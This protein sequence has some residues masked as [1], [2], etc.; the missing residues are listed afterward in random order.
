MK[1]QSH[2]RITKIKRDKIEEL[3]KQAELISV[4]DGTVVQP[5]G[6]DLIPYPDMD[7]LRL[8]TNHYLL[9]GVNKIYPTRIDNQGTMY[10]TAIVDGLPLHT[11][12]T[13]TIEG[14]STET[15][16]TGKQLNSNVLTTIGSPTFNETTGVVSGFSAS[17]Y[18]QIKPE[19]IVPGT[20]F[21]LCVIVGD[22]SISTLQRIDYSYSMMQLNQKGSYIASW[23]D[24]SPSGE[25][26]VVSNL[27]TGQEIYIKTQYTDST[28]VTIRYS[29]DG[30]EYTTV[31]DNVED[32][33]YWNST[34]A[35][36]G[37]LYYIGTNPAYPATSAQYFHGS[38]DFSKSYVRLSSGLPEYLATD[39]TEPI[40]LTS[41]TSKPG[42]W[43]S[44][45]I[46]PVY[47]DGNGSYLEH[48][49]VHSNEGS[50][51][52]FNSDII[53]NYSYSFIQRGKF[54]KH[55]EGNWDDGCFESVW[56]SGANSYNILYSPNIHS[57]TAYP[58]LWAFQTKFD[59]SYTTYQSIV[60]PSD[61]DMQKYQEADSKCVSFNNRRYSNTEEVTLYSS[62][63]VGKDWKYEL[64]FY[65]NGNGSGNDYGNGGN[66]DNDN[67]FNGGC[68]AGTITYQDSIN[69]TTCTQEI[70][71]CFQT[72]QSYFNPDVPDID[73][74]SEPKPLGSTKL[75]YALHKQYYG[76]GIFATAANVYQNDFNSSN[77][78][79]TGITG[80]IS[81]SMAGTRSCLNNSVDFTVNYFDGA[82]DNISTGHNF[83]KGPY[84]GYTE[85]GGNCGWTL[86]SIG[87]GYPNIAEGGCGYCSCY[88][89]C[90][91]G[92]YKIKFIEGSPEAQNNVNIYMNIYDLKAEA[93]AEGLPW[94]GGCGE[95][96]FTVEFSTSKCDKP[97][98]TSRVIAS[99]VDINSLGDI[100]RLNN[101]TITG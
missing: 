63:L 48:N 92:Q 36:N 89:G 46:Y 1:R 29:F 76:G 41:E 30:S 39:T 83:V 26:V 98:C 22:T 45:F 58:A 15:I 79:P 47:G 49:K 35:T 66:P 88:L 27:T 57:C 99:N 61:P 64:R 19:Y 84:R 13:K 96:R 91:A 7:R 12:M 3:L 87:T 93:E 71:S 10:L 34:D 28:H 43:L 80:T 38:I 23:K 25:K 37:T 2:Q 94:T 52:K 33:R 100:S 82:N 24:T 56:N 53:G 72:V 60:V 54:A 65:G 55:T 101:I 8:W 9:P 31:Y 20:E 69:G 75:Y 32:A 18:Y 44:N 67:G 86:G 74:W 97:G 81:I 14:T 78:F 77:S 70:N 95:A 6:A 59:N 85:G 51:D 73:P 50:F 17:N 21:C 62:K 16:V 5:Q 90:I 40:T 4:E 68:V 11:K 42:L